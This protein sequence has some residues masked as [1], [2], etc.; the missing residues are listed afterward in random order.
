MIPHLKK[1]FDNLVDLQLDE[2]EVIGL[3][4]ISLEGERV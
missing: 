1:I 2:E 3:E 4:M